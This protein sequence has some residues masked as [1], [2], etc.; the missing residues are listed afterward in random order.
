MERLPIIL[1]RWSHNV[2]EATYCLYDNKTLQPISD[3]PKQIDGYYAVYREGV[4]CVWLQNDVPYCS[5]NGTTCLVDATTQ[6]D[7]QSTCWYRQFRITLPNQSQIAF[8]YHTFARNI[9]AYL[10]SFLFLDDDW[11]LNHDLPSHVHSCHRLKDFSALIS[12]ANMA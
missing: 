7:W 1:K 11:G 6:I 12:R 2:G 3:E 4:F 5:W 10:Q 8:K 9:W